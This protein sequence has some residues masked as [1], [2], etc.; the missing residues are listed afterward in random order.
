M[1]PVSICLHNV[2]QLNTRAS[3][4]AGI[5]REKPGLKSIMQHFEFPPDRNDVTG[6]AALNNAWLGKYW[7]STNY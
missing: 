3:L 2:L 1:A 5:C 7:Y 4:V 6:I